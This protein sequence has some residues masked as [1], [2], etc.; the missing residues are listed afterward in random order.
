[1]GYVEEHQVRVSSIKKAIIEQK[2]AMPDR[3]K[4]EIVN[5]DEP[6]FD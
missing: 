1:M 5:R 3:K 2:L 6:Q 4:R